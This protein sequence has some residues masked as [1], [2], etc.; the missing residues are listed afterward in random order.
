MRFTEM[1]IQ[2]QTRKEMDHKYQES[3]GKIIINRPK[4]R[5]LIR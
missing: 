2:S 4:G 3:A 5:E 1:G